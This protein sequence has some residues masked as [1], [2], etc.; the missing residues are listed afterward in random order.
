M[1]KSRN[2]RSKSEDKMVTPLGK[3]LY[4]LRYAANIPQREIAAYLGIS[5]AAYSYYELGTIEP[6]LMVLKR[7]SD[8][9]HISLKELLDNI[10]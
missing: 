7:I 9:H 5:R 8:F 2:M 3:R 1:P 10:D 4:E 6:S